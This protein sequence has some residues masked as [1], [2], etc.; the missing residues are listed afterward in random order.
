LRGV[1]RR[2]PEN[3]LALLLLAQTHI[4][5]GDNALAEDA[6]RRILQVNARNTE[7]INGLAGIVGGSGQL[8]E[9]QKLYADALAIDAKNAAALEGMVGIMLARKDVKAAEEHARRLAALDDA[10][11]VGQRTLGRVLEAQRN[12]PAATEAYKRALEKNPDSRLALEGVARTLQESGRGRDATDYLRAHLEEH[13]DHVLARILLGGSLLRQRE[14]EEARTV[15]DEALTQQPNLMRGY[16]VLAATYPD[17]PDARVGVYQRA[18]EA[19]PT[20]GDIAVLLAG[21]YQSRGR[22]EDAIALYEQMLERKDD[23][24]QVANNLAVLL[25]D[26]R[27][28]AASHK[29]A[30]EIAQRFTNTQQPMYLDTLGWAHYRNED[31]NSAIRF[32]ELAVAFGRIEP[33][34]RYHLA[35]AY[36]ATDNRE[37]ARQEL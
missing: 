20:A 5:N 26:Q 1:L 2:E 32:L 36:L 31:F 3:E 30:L 4:A 17:D 8:D 35:M 25:L 18:L 11:G 24:P 34:A 7:A 33:E 29:R 12:L 19:N 16:I 37:G 14:F 23:L 13:P 27:T 21:E 9:A 22:V 6:Y 15:L 10:D 28:D